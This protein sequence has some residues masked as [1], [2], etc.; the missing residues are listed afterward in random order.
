MT[1]K[2]NSFFKDINQYINYIKY[3]DF[4]VMI[5]ISVFR[6][7]RNDLIKTGCCYVRYIMFTMFLKVLLHNILS[8]W[9]TIIKRPK[10]WK[11]KERQ[12]RKPD[13]GICVAVV[14]AVGQNNRF[15]TTMRF[16]KFGVLY[17]SILTHI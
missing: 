1:M 17:D 6:S 11:K 13:N 4:T 2:V 10:K 15:G 5:F 7:F 3:N 16:K 9:K 14:F 12:Y 8:A